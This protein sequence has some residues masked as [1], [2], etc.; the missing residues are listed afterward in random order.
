M[1]QGL[2]AESDLVTLSYDEK[3]G[4]QALGVTTPDRPPVPGQ[5]GSHLRD[6]EYKRLGTVSLLAGLDLHTGI[7]TEIVSDTHKSSDFIA[8]LTKLDAAYPPIQKLR[9][10]LDKHSAHISRETQ[11]WLSGSIRTYTRECIRIESPNS[12]PCLSE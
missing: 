7:V 2:I 4:I 3:P 10:I 12:H 9:L 5:H 1:L 11:R 6:Y 8:F